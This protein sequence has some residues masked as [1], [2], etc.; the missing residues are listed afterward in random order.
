MIKFYRAPR[1]IHNNY[2]SW[3]SDTK[4]GRKTFINRAEDSE[5]KYFNDVD[6]TGTTFTSSQYGRILE[7]TGMPFSANLIQPVA[8]QKLA[9]L[10]QTKPSTKVMSLDGRAKQH[11]A[12]LDKMKFAVM[13][14]GKAQMEIESMIRDMLI[15]GM[16]HLMVVPMSAYQGGLFNTGITYVPFDEVIL[17]INAKK[18]SLED[19]EGFFI[20]KAFTEPKFLI[21]YADIMANLTD[22]ATGEPVSHKTFTN[23]TWMEDRLSD[24]QK[25]TTTMWNQDNFVVV[26]EYYEKIF[27]TMYV[28]PNP[29]TGI[30]QYLFQENM[31]LDQESLLSM[32]VQTFP[33]MY[34]KKTLVF[35]DFVTWEETMPVTTWP[36]VTSFFEWGGRPYRS[37]GMVHFTKGMSDAFEKSMQIMVLNGILANNSGWKAPKGSIAEEDRPKWEDY[38]NNPRVIKE[39]VPVVREGQVFIPERETPAQIGN[40]FPYLLDL[41]KSGIEYSTG[42]T[43]ILQGDASESGVEVFSSL[44]QYQNAAMQ[45]I[46]LST[47]HINQTMVDLGQVLI[48]YLTYNIGPENYTFF[49]EKGNLNELD[50]AKEIANDI[51]LHR[52]LSVAVPSTAMPTQ[53][54]AT[55]TELMKIAQSSPDPVE[56][57]L[58]T[59][60]A[61]DLSEI[62][63]FDDLREKLDVV[64]KTNAQ[65][66]QL[67][68]AYERL[69][70][71]SKQME[72][73]YINISLE[74]RILKQMMGKEKQIAEAYAKMETKISIAEDLANKDSQDKQKPKEGK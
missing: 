43:P 9:I 61:M 11:A 67:Q 47:T 30:Y 39:Y 45:R 64:K 20:E 4:Y 23:T 31:D 37:Y 8:N 53:R 41:L 26:R 52:Y 14:H 72:N 44:Q 36:L 6:D 70:E 1:Y 71:T 46:M 73:K 27:S 59:Q 68:Q 17:D 18:K 50:L 16:G 28:V 58:Y 74:N 51:K 34:I 29:E 60:T 13:Y 66:A 63:E 32:A 55:A 7:T 19:M 5:E 24:K 69:E 65:L 42:I 2:V 56:R 49:D 12:V 40:F 22:P 35:G 57:S 54:L 10:T 62:R 33:G 15:T 21:L 25:V 3:K 38:A 48:E